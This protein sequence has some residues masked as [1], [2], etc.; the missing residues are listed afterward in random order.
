MATFTNNVKINNVQIASTEPRYSNRAW[1]G[2][3]ITR[4]T[5]IQYYTLQFTLSFK[6]QNVGEYNNF[7]ALYSRGQPF[8]FSLG[9]LSQYKGSQT[10]VVSTSSAAGKGVYQ[11]QTTNNTLEIGTMVQFQNHSK[12]YRI[13]GRQGNTV[14]LFPNLRTNVQAGETVRYMGIEGTFTLA[15]DN[16]YSLPINNV[17][18]VTLKASEYLQ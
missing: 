2:S 12:I 13:I 5:G 7:F 18:S 9:H 8:T 16:D 17:M 4:S 1:S 11:I 10:G 15:V 6:Q 14:M 3:E